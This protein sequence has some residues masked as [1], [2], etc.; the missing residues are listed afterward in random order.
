[1]DS[2]NQRWLDNYP[3]YDSY[4]SYYYPES[5]MK[6][7]KYIED[8]SSVKWVRMLE[9]NISSF[10][11]TISSISNTLEQLLE[12][13]QRRVETST[14]VKKVEHE[15]LE[16]KEKV[17]LTIV[18]HDMSS[19]LEI[20]R[21]RN[22]ILTFIDIGLKVGVEIEFDNHETQSLHSSPLAQIQTWNRQATVKPPEI[23]LSKA[24]PTFNHLKSPTQ[25]TSSSY[26]AWRP[27]KRASGLIQACPFQAKSWTNG[28][29]R[30]LSS[31]HPRSWQWKDNR[32]D[33]FGTTIGSNELTPTE[34]SFFSPFPA[35]PFQAKSWTKGHERRLR[36]I[37][38]EAGF[39]EQ[40][41]PPALGS[42]RI[43]GLIHSEPPWLNELTPTGPSFFSPF[44]V[45]I[46]RNSDCPIYA[47]S[48]FIHCTEDMLNFDN[49]IALTSSFILRTKVVVDDPSE[50]SVSISTALLLSD[51]IIT[52]VIAHN[53][54]VR[55]E[56][57]PMNR[58][59]PGNQLPCES[60]KMPPAADQFPLSAVAPSELTF[61]QPWQGALH[62]MEIVLDESSFNSAAAE[63]LW[64]SSKHEAELLQ[65]PDG[66]KI[67][68]KIK[69]NMVQS[70]SAHRAILDQRG[71]SLVIDDW[72][73]NMDMT[74]GRVQRT[75][76]RRAIGVIMAILEGKSIRMSTLMIHMVMQL[77]WVQGEVNAKTKNDDGPV[78][79]SLLSHV[80]SEWIKLVILPLSRERG[81]RCPVKPASRS[82]LTLGT[83]RIRVYTQSPWL[84]SKLG[85]DK[86]KLNHP[87]SN[88]AKPNSHSITLKPP[89]RL[90]ARVTELGYQ[91]RGQGLYI[92]LVP[93]D[94]GR[95]VKMI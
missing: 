59:N 62:L 27:A 36:G 69:I 90:Q 13:V 12:T 94:F 22:A 5:N 64:T 17:H 63:L 35:C 9:D 54:I 58:Q 25:V 7:D 56:P 32:L 48:H 83:T 1:M 30:R 42:G 68:Q 11:D 19:E 76:I 40:R 86:P 82:T 8:S 14:S 92:Q 67:M 72:E 49:L 18:E 80:G 23:R 88:S 84:N 66:K 29:E 46:L 6:N 70:R 55:A 53:S 75:K 28:H 44:P 39:T 79:V 37:K 38:R 57:L 4:F 51:T 65:A 24:K 15:V 74:R 10:Q 87:R 41:T 2:Y 45:F 34:P 3:T 26:Q 50:A 60:R 20:M 43:T 31:E 52:L 91:H 89:L 47:I 95:C 21:N 71:S 85:M 61:T 93:F 16:L 78:R 73:I 33:P 77:R 81:L